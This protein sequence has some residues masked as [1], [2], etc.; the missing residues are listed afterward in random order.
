MNPQKH[1]GYMDLIEELERYNRGRDPERL[2]LKYQK[3]RDGPF[4]FLRGNCHGFASRLAQVDVAARGPVGW[5]CGDLHLENFGSYKGDNRQVYFD[6]NDFDEALLAPAAWD[7][8]HVLT[9]FQVVA[10]QGHVQQ[11]T[12]AVLV[13]QMLEHYFGAL[14]AGKPL[15]VER[16][17]AQGPVQRLLM[18]LRERT[19]E[20]FLARRTQV[21]GR[22]R[23]LRV[24][25]V[26]ALPASQAERDRATRIVHAYGEEQDRREF[27]EVLDVANRIAGTGS[28]GLERYAVL[29]R[30]KGPPAGHYILDVKHA[31]ES[32]SARWVKDKQPAWHSEAHRVVALQQRLQAV[33]MAFLS[34]RVDG[35]RAYVLR[36]LQPL[37]DRVMIDGPTLAPKD[38]EIV[39]RTMAQ[40]TAWAHLRGS[41]RQG[42]AVAD[43]WIEWGQSQRRRKSLLKA[44]E[45][46]A[47]QVDLDWRLFA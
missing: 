7:V 22:R 23:T 26:K 17:T 2:A 27:F 31:V 45:H 12:A 21:R 32:S 19:R 36:A 20:E 46:L 14:A 1:E 34:P 33:S 16:E 13:A 24:D 37:E 38:L 28:L 18:R 35:R 39:L 41:G 15:W 43:E 47:R 44:V 9:S 8:L 6:L 10:R 4:T 5:I 42:A 25:G 29:V 40:C 30:G 3:M 11:D